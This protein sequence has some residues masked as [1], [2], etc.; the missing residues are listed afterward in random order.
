VVSDSTYV[1]NCVKNRW[2]AGWLRK[3]WRSTAGTP[4][5]NRDLW[6]PFVELITAD[7]QR[8]TFQ[9]VKGHS[10]NPFNDL[11]DTL[12]TEACLAQRAWEGDL[13][14]ILSRPA[15]PG[16]SWPGLT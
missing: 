7:P 3:D 12:A 6:K 11:V 15:P 5:A 1:V 10:D 13:T 14:S 8:Y 4:V 9:W 16:R 2:Y